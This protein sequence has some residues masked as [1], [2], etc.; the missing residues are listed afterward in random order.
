MDTALQDVVDGKHV[1]EKL[2]PRRALA[3]WLTEQGYPISY[4]TITKYCSPAIN[5]GPPTEAYWGRLP[6][7]RPSRALEWARARLRPAAPS[8]TP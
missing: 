6:M 2:L 5:C 4:S 3:E 1:D 8:A 7:H